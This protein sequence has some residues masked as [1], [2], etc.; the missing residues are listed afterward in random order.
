MFDKNKPLLGIDIGNVITGDTDKNVLFS[1][2][3]LDV[4]EIDGAFQGVRELF[5]R[6]SGQVCLVSKCGGIVQA[7][8]RHWLL[9]H[10][11]Y[12]LT[13]VNPGHVFF[14]EKREGKAPICRF[15]GVSHFVDDRLEVLGYLDTVRYKYLFKPNESEIARNIAHLPFV[16]RIEGWEELTS[17]MTI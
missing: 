9:H 15:L 12:A 16:Q 1:E 14:C 11:F 5:D 10:N 2:R 8:T 4:S 6:F 13:G 17:L 3:Y 7:K